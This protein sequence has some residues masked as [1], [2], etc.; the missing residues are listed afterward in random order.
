MVQTWRRRA[1]LGGSLALPVLARAQGAAPAWP[2]QPIRLVVP[3]APG[4]TTDLVARLV[5][6]PLQEKLGQPIIVENRPGAGAT[7]GSLLVAQAPPDGHT[8]V[9]SNIASHA[10]SPTLYG[11]IRY[12]PLRDF[13]H[14][15]LLTLNPSVF[16]ANPRTGIANLADLARLHRQRGLDMA[17]S[18][19][20]S[21]N[22]LLIV[23]MGGLLGR[24]INHI[25][26]RG[27]GP[28]M[29]AVIG[30]QVP[31]MS[32]S[33]PSAAAHIRQGSVTAVAMSSAERHP[34][35]PN[36]PTFREQGYDVV[37]SSW[38]GLSGPANLP[39]P[40]VD[41]LAREVGTI[42][43]SD[44]T[45]MRF[46]EI[47]GSPGRFSPEEYAAFVASEVALWGPLVRETGARP[48]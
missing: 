42:L 44:S 11:N 37:A 15:A 1:I 33:L 5:A 34:S 8:L 17:S 48:D 19:S 7:V 22:H 45:R 16:V 20:G 10:I 46:A 6:T 9:L 18:G 29:T 4:G 36:V 30:G 24:E 26:F 28:A 23:K 31:L 3:F 40:I 35:F 39:R 27:A 21:S 12:D 32:D 47:G 38:F 25:P 2:S 43:D 14:I 13:S 41:R